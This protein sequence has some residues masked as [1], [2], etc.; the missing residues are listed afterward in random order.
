[1]RIVYTENL[2]S[3]MILATP[4]YDRNE[5]L[6][7]KDGN[8]LSDK[9]IKLLGNKNVPYVFIS[10]KISEGVTIHNILSKKIRTKLL[11]NYEE[12]ISNIYKKFPKHLKTDKDRLNFCIHEKL[13][14]TLQIRDIRHLIE[15]VLCDI[16]SV[17][18]KYQYYSFY[19][20]KKNFIEQ[21]IEVTLISILIGRTFDYTRQELIQL[22]TSAFLCNIGLIFS[23]SFN[24]KLF[25]YDN[26][27]DAEP[28]HTRNGYDFLRE[29]KTLSAIEYLSTFEHH[30]L[31]NGKGYPERKTSDQSIPVRERKEHVNQIFRF[32]EIISVSS[33]LID[34]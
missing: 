17:D 20:H 19:K 3:G 9:L 5:R 16:E 13:I 27:F 15:E 26:H 24:S 14:R 12:F 7:L 4:N 33:N 21:S 18:K 23:K 25:T 6:L 32:S 22:G 29:S 11:E 1:M 30:E 8:A 31:S 28:Q 10:D 2:K 34:L